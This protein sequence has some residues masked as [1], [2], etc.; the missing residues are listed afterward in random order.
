M[1]QEARPFDL[2]RLKPAIGAEVQGLDLSA[3]LDDATIDCREA[4]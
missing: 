3:E 2:I 4:V 1:R